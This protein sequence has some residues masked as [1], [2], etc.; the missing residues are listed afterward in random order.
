MVHTLADLDIR[1]QSLPWYLLLSTAR[2]AEDIL[3]V[4]SELAPAA[5]MYWSGSESLL[6]P[7]HGSHEW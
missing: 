5:M 6:G 7:E 3:K 1:S 2:T 4:M